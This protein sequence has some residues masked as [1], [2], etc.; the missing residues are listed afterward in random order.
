MFI[1][2]LLRSKQFSNLLKINISISMLP[3]DN[4][5]DLI[6]KRIKR[7]SKFTL[8]GLYF[9]CHLLIKF[10]LFNQITVQCNCLHLFLK[11]W[12]CLNLFL[13][14]LLNIDLRLLKNYFIFLINI[15]IRVILI[16]IFNLFFNLLILASHQQS[17]KLYNNNI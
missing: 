17:T 12:Q 2:L 7:F 6:G 11:S 5:V 15:K 1:F 8:N 10:S 4:I 13:N 3:W 9:R 16:D 14:L